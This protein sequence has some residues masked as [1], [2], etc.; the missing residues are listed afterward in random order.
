MSQQSES[1]RKHLLN[2]HAHQA[3]AGVFLTSFATPCCGGLFCQVTI[4]PIIISEELALI[5]ESTA[6]CL[7]QIGTNGN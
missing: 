3:N 4:Q 1:L 6:L 2:I 5:K 7:G